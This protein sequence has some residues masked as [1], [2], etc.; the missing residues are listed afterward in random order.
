MRRRLFFQVYLTFLAIIVLFGVLTALAWWF[1]P[2]EHRAGDFTRGMG[3]YL[4][5]TLPPAGAPRHQMDAHLAR[6]ARHFDVDLTLFAADGSVLGS[7]GSGT[8]EERRRHRHAIM[9]P[10]GRTMEVDWSRNGVS[11]AGFIVVPGLLA[12]AAAIG[13]WPLS[14]RLAG[15]LERLKSRVE[16][17]GSGDLQA[18]VKVEGR[19]EIAALATSFNRA[20]GRIENLVEAQRNTLAAASHELRSPLARIAMATGLLADYADQDLVARIERDIAELDQLIDEILL[21]SRLEIDEGPARVDEIDLGAL[22][23]EEAARFEVAFTGGTA[24]IEVEKHLVRHLVRNLLGNARRHAAGSPVSVDV[25]ADGPWV[26][27]RVADRGPGVSESMRESI[28][29]PFRSFAADGKGAGL[30]LYLV[31]RIARR[32]GGDAVCLERPDGGALFEV[33]LPARGEEQGP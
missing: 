12:L 5:E 10:D 26:R 25:S 13:A 8:G 3:S 1:I 17:L 6:L 32:Y 29:E 11:G 23:A 18:R 7:A 14:R 9:L 31:R 4:Q 30:G 22:A 24:V 33:S 28:F 27:L 16:A 21:G 15:R 20:A 19:D 2:D